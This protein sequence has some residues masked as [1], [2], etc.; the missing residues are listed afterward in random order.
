MRTLVDPSVHARAE[1]RRTWQTYRPAALP[2][3]V[4]CESWPAVP[5][6]FEGGALGES[7]ARGEVARAWLMALAACDELLEHRDWDTLL[8]RSVELLRERIGLERAAIFLLDPSGKRLFGTWGTDAEG[9]TTDERGIAFDVGT[10]HREAFTHAKTGSAQWS[11]F[12]GVP[13]FAETT[14][15]TVVLRTGENVIIP[16]PGRDGDLGLVACDWAISGARADLETL[17]RATVFTRV[18]APQLEWLA[19]RSVPSGPEPCT[20][21]GPPV[22]LEGNDTRLSAL[23]AALLHDDPNTDR[24]SLARKLGTTP[25]RLGRAFK[26]ALGESVGE[27]RNRVRV[28]RFL[29]VVDPRGGNLLEAALDA[30]F[31]SYAQFH[32]VFRRAFGRSPIEYL[33]EQHDRR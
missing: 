19:L 7:R 14:E 30:G 22:A 16:I 20:P 29:V 25:G 2:L 31:G 28:Q 13:L 8:R 27:Y 10:S 6:R 17:L 4:L 9:R 5:P 12:D 33:R 18:L 24:A 23:A 21:V 1:V 15:G 11:R 32:R 3:K 26:T